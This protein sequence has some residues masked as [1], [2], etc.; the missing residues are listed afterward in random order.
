MTHR[1]R[2]D[3]GRLQSVLVTMLAGMLSSTACSDAVDPSREAA[4]AADEGLERSE[5][6]EPSEPGPTQPA[7][8][9]FDSASSLR[10]LA[11]PAP[12]PVPEGGAQQPDLYDPNTIPKFELTFDKSAMD[13]L[14]RL[15]I[16]TKDTWVHGAFKYGGITFADVGVRGKGSHSFRVLPQK[17]SLKVKFNKWVKG[18]KLYGLEELTLNNMVADRTALNQR[19][20]YHVFRSLGLPAQK[21]NTSQLVINGEDYGI[22]ANVE[23]PDEN[24]LARVFGATAGSLYE[25]HDGPA[26]LPGTASRWETD[27]EAPGAPVGTRPDL[28]LLLEAVSAANDSTLLADLDSTLHTKQWLRFCAAE[29]V[30]GQ[31]DGY[32]FNN[33]SHNYFMAGD[34]SGK[35]S[36]VPWSLDSTLNEDADLLPAST[37][38]PEVVL[39]RCSKSSICWNAYKAE[40]ESVL[41]AYEALDLVTLATA[42][43]AQIDALQKAD[44]K[45][46]I[47]V[48][49]YESHTKALYSWLAQ[50]PSDIRGHLGL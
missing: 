6:S 4:A 17:A 22:Y 1:S 31:H 26:W 32:A 16:D 21:A 48:S 27:V 45:R 44:P 38:H 40:M 49:T 35:F 2:P 3:A 30:T 23:T 7:P 29:V 25:V 24:F 11:V 8:V 5:P 18:Q 47:E 14:E 46:E 43:H 42:W 13:V 50:R 28:D 41:K 36:L 10:P 9:S 19:L 15:T 39:T 12:P 20:S 34:T 33:H 37:P